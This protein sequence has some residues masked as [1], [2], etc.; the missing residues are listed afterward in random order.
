MSFFIV[1][2]EVFN[3]GLKPN[4][5]AVFAYLCSCADNKT[6][7]CFPS[8]NKIAKACGMGTS[9]V[10]AVIHTLAEKGLIKIKPRY[11]PIPGSEK[12][13][14][15][16]NLYVV[17]LL[18]ECRQEERELE[19]LY[20]SLGVEYRKPEGAPLANR[21]QLTIP[22]ITTP[23]IENKPFVSKKSCSDASVSD[24]PDFN[25]VKDM[26]VNEIRHHYD[27][28]ISGCADIVDKAL[29]ELWNDRIFDGDIDPI[30][31][32]NILLKRLNSNIIIKALRCFDID[33]T[34]DI[35]PTS[36]CEMLHGELL[37][38]D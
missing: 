37:R 17:S 32:Q 24:E 8:V 1:P 5:I 13:R 25:N 31:A 22:N 27:N 18:K 23:H 21:G 28:E 11:N 34:Y 38:G 19:K 36:L 12:R 4:E 16:S 20:K 29:A 14:Q 33:G 30:V 35:N 7:E 3:Y 10:R 9:T 15:T 6:Y 2:N 26:C